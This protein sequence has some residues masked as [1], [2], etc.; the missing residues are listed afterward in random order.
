MA[1]YLVAQISI[2]DRE[3]YG[4]YEA[5]FM[6]IFMKYN[7]RLLAVDEAPQVHEGEWSYT[8]TG[9]IEFP[10]TEDANAWYESDEYQ[11]LA[12]HRK[13]SSDANIILING[14]Q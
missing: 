3:R 8:S 14:L 5:G 12:V 2:D 6:E 10:T 13:A 4:Q 7:G 9:L 11:A 1:A